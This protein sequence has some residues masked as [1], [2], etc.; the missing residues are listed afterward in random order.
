MAI[1]ALVVQQ[2][3]RWILL[4]FLIL[5]KPLSFSFPTFSIGT[6]DL[7]PPG[8]Y[9]YSSTVSDAP[10]EVSFLFFI[11]KN[12]WSALIELLLLQ[13]MDSKLTSHSTTP[14]GTMHSVASESRT[15]VHSLSVLQPW[16]HSIRW[17]LTFTK[18]VVGTSPTVPLNMVRWAYSS[19]S[20]ITRE[21]GSFTAVTN[22]RRRTRFWTVR[23]N[24]DFTLGDLALR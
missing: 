21:V 16:A 7:M 13:L 14:S 8:K 5:S 18:C 17:E 3:M 15:T 19:L 23:C 1:L 4:S 12:F 10:E 22:K 9:Y 11:C 6:G 20:L 2:K 24:Y